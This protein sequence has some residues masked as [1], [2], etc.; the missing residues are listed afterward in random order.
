MKERR[1][2][3]KKNMPDEKKCKF[4]VVFYIE[5]YQCGVTYIRNY[6]KIEWK[7]VTANENLKKTDI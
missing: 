3:R 2:V 4:F 6:I 5:R 1:T 7:F